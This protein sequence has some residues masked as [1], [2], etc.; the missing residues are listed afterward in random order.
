[1]LLDVVGEMQKP[2]SFGACSAC[3]ARLAVELKSWSTATRAA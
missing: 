2:V 3:S 1:M